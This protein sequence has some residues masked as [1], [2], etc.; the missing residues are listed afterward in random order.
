MFTGIVEALGE[1][2]ERKAEGTNVHF[3]IRSGISHQVEIDN[4]VAHNGVCLTVTKT[5]GD[6]HWVTAV[7]ETL[8]RT[9]LG[10][11]QTGS[12]VNLERSLRFNGR[13][14]GH[15]VQGHVDAIAVCKL[16]EPNDG[17]WLYTF[18]IPP[19]RLLVHKGSVC[20]NGVSLTVIDPTETNF[21]VA[22]IPFTYDNTTF[23]FL[24]VGDAVN[25]EFD[26]IGKYVER[27][28]RT[29]K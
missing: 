24:S 9:N 28:L 6:S 18:D 17:S 21:S 10:L 1:V 16:V 2:I 25:I 4:S 19:S 23:R 26:I 15:L 5:D 13:V 8:K 27:M 11:L 22:L 14:E 12:K 29:E 7:D 3:R 20:V